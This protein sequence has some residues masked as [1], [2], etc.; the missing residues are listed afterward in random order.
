M[1]PPLNIKTIIQGSSASTIN[2]SA[3]ALNMIGFLKKVKIYEEI[4]KSNGELKP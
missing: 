1:R 4:T 3:N 2:A